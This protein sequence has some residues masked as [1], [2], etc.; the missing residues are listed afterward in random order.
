MKLYE[1]NQE[2]EDAVANLD[3]DWET[4]EIGENYDEELMG[5][6]QELAIEKKNLLE[7]LAKLALNTKAE[8]E[9]IKAEERRLKARREAKDHRYDALIRVLD[10]ECGEKTDF[11]VATL[12]YRKTKST[13]ITDERKVYEWLSSN[14]KTQAFVIPA[15]KLIRAEIKKIIEAGEE[16]PG[17]EIVQKQSCSLR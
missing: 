9:A 8:S 14:G 5:R 11:G 3:F 17:A 15:P 1:I 2:L 4:G 7:Y 13:E 12:S 6:I 16:I 10:R